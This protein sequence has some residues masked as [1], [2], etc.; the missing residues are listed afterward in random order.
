MFLVSFIPFLRKSF[1]HD[2]T[3]KGGP[4]RRPMAC[5]SACLLA[6]VVCASSR[7]NDAV[8]H[9]GNDCYCTPG[10][11]CIG[12]SVFPFC[13]AH[14]VCAYIDVIPLIRMNV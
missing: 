5:D 13:I 11:C 12:L 10:V 7:I 14:V 6:H 3:Q 1:A 2:R 8:Y 9:H 4:L